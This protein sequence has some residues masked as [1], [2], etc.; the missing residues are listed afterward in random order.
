MNPASGGNVSAGLS[1]G[2][3]GDNTTGYGS[4]TYTNASGNWTVGDEI[5]GT[6]SG[7]R[8]II[9][10]IDSPGATQT[11]H[12]Y[13][14]GD[15]LVDFNTAIEVADNQDDT[16]A[17]SK[18]GSAPA[19]QGP[20]LAGWFD[21]AAL[22][23][24]A[25]ANDQVDIADTG[26]P[27]EWGIT[28]D[29][30]QGSLAQMY[31]WNKYNLR[32]GSIV[33]QDGLDGQEWIGIDYAINYS[34]ITGTVGEGSVVTGQTS[35]ATGTVVSNPGGSSNTALL[36]DTRGTFVDGEDISL[37]PASHEFDA[38]GLTVEAITPVAASSYGTLAGG[39]FFGT[40]GVVLTDY[41][42]GEENS[43]TLLDATGVTRQRPTSIT[44]TASTLLVNDWVAAYRLTAALGPIDKTEYSATG[45]ETEGG[46]TITVDGTIAVDVPNKDNGGRIVLRDKDDSNTEYVLRFSSFVPSTGV[47]TLANNAFA[48]TAGTDDN[49]LFST[50]NLTAANVQV[51]DLIVV[52]T[53]SRGYAYVKT[54]VSDNEVEL[55]RDITGLVSTDNFEIN[56]VPNITVN[57]LD[58][59][60]FP[61]ILQFV[62]A[63]TSV[64]VS[65]QYVGDIECRGRVRNT[66]DAAT[67][68]K[69]FSTDFQVGTGGGS[70]SATRIEN[71]VY[72]S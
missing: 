50:G 8:G 47:I 40:R 45:G 66:A 61:I 16:G 28:I 6:D 68:I 5:L 62:A 32:R 27:Q 10:Q 30:N 7:A 60:Y 11:V 33:D 56:A 57:T 18:N 9:T 46:A 65:M 52:T 72:G 36:R 13:L 4:I 22:P 23:T 38:S 54:R 37:T 43:F 64:A 67:K 51:G 34:T 29:L 44:V 19:S 55:D 17:G 49:T 1:S 2:V 58:D 20:A 24:I 3:D 69:G 53:S 35:G 71:T 26:T 21:G 59:V 14:V 15:P 42:S 39:L 25:F 31:E 48:A 41:K 63:G 70:F 12:Y